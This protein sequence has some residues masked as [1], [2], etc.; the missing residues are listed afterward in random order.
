MI[1]LRLIV[2]GGAAVLTVTHDAD[3]HGWQFLSGGE[4]DMADAAVVALEEM[5]ARDPSLMQV[6][7]LSPG[8]LAWRA[9]SSAAWQREP[10]PC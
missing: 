4:F 8:W 6:A 1:T 5:V 7:D 10:H 9:S 3:D 2:F